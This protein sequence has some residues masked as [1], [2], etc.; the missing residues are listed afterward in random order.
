LALPIVIPA[1]MLLAIEKMKLMP[2]DKKMRFLVQIMCIFT[3]LNVAV[4][5]ATAIFP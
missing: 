3:E 1:L 5:M 2:K 4:P